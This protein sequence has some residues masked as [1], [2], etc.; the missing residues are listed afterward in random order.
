[1][2]YSPRILR[3]GFIS[4]KEHF[5]LTADLMKLWG[6]NNSWWTFKRPERGFLE[7]YLSSELSKWSQNRT[8]LLLILL[9]FFV[10]TNTALFGLGVKFALW[11]NYIIWALQAGNLTILRAE[12]FRWLMGRRKHDHR[13]VLFHP[14]FLG[15]D[16]WCCTLSKSWLHRKKTQKKTQKATMLQQSHL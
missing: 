6:I 11:A 1:M 10:P 15:V 3:Y 16:G 8:M 14:L 13:L 9:L 2:P 12:S 7:V 5:H 4:L